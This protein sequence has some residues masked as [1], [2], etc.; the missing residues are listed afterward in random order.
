M[1]TPAAGLSALVGSSP[2]L[3]LLGLFTCLGDNPVCIEDIDPTHPSGGF[4]SCMLNPENACLEGVDLDR[5]LVERDTLVPCLMEN[6]C[7]DNVSLPPDSLGFCLASNECL[8]DIDMDT[9]FAERDSLVPCLMENSCLDF[10]LDQAAEDSAGRCLVEKECFAGFDLGTPLG[11]R[12][13]LIPCMLE[14]DCFSG[15]D[16]ESDLEDRDGLVSCLARNPECI[17]PDAAIPINIMCIQSIPILNPRPVCG[18][19]IASV[20]AVRCL[21]D[22]SPI[23]CILDAATFGPGATKLLQCISDDSLCGDKADLD[24]FIGC[25]GGDDSNSALQCLTDNFVLGSGLSTFGSCVMDDDLCG[26]KFDIQALVACV[27]EDEADIFTCVADNIALGSGVQTLGACLVE[28]EKCADKVSISEGLN[29]AQGCP[30]DDAS[31][32]L[33]CGM[34]SIGIAPG[35]TTFAGCLVDEQKCAKDLDVMGLVSCIQDPEQSTLDC[36]TGGYVNFASGLLEVASCTTVG[37]CADKF[38][39]LSLILCATTSDASLVECALDSM[40]IGLGIKSA[41]SCVMNDDKC[42][43]KVNIADGIVC[44]QECAAD[45]SECLAGCLVSAIEISPAM[46]TLGECLVD[47]EICGD[48]LDIRAGLECFAEADDLFTALDECMGISLPSPPPPSPTLPPPSPTA[49]PPLS[50]SAPPTAAPPTPPNSNEEET[51]STFPTGAV[52]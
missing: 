10:S 4:G 28:E 25:I 1:T 8:A 35:I 33:S 13:T 49:T 50:P 52:A 41:L 47:D 15:I 16:L 27:T 5:P 24:G 18:D 48:I 32:V 43:D 42:G 26:E 21:N 2:P 17:T 37:P 51:S 9:P 11:E 36:I 46:I 7:L 29:C 19:Y 14:H 39:A 44:A 38:D 23:S 3:D 22:P 45:D 6:S 34:S 20:D 30:E 40:S 12:D 31:C